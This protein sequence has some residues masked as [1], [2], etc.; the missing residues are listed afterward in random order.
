MMIRSP[1]AMCRALGRTV[2]N[3]AHGN[4][5]VTI[6]HPIIAGLLLAAL[7]GFP[8]LQS[9]RSGRVMLR[10]PNR[11][12]YRR[13]R[14]GAFWGSIALSGVVAVLGLALALWGALSG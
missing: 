3:E 7:A 6:R 9:L 10:G 5:G 14:P 4:T 13:K 1:T 11:P 2:P 12:I 8:A